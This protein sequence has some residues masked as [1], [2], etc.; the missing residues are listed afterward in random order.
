MV[1]KASPAPAPTPL[2]TPPY[3]D[4]WILVLRAR[5]EPFELLPRIW[6]LQNAGFEPDLAVLDNG[7]VLVEERSRFAT[8]VHDSPLERHSF[9]EHSPT[10]S[11][12]TGRIFSCGT[13]CIDAM[14]SPER[15]NCISCESITQVAKGQRLPTFN[16]YITMWKECRVAAE[17]PC[18]RSKAQASL[19]A[20]L[21]AAAVKP[22]MQ[23]TR[24]IAT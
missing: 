7:L 18:N 15:F 8:G 2:L 1:I 6:V 20:G 16:V 5:P 9:N 23:S 19:L 22:L 21:L 14:A 13:T 24:S 3:I 4:L 12:G 17:R 11:T 10:G